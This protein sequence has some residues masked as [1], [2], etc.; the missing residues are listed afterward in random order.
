VL[1]ERRV[2]GPRRVLV[3]E[4]VPEHL[5]LRLAHRR[6]CVPHRAVELAY[7]QVP[8]GDRGGEGLHHG[9]VVADGRAGHVE[10]DDR[11]TAQR[12]VSSAIA[13]E[14]VIPRP[15]GP[16]TRTTPGLTALRW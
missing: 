13:G 12:N 8:A 4:D 1:L 6:P 16:V 10:A 14:Q 3:T 11:E 5:D 7:R 2:G 15:P 9:V